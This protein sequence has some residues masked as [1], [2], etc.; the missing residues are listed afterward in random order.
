MA[1]APKFDLT[2]LRQ[3]L[4]RWSET[5]PDGG[6]FSADT[7][8]RWYRSQ[9]EPR[10]PSQATIAKYLADGKGWAGA[11]IA[12]RTAIAAV[13]PDRTIVVPVICRARRP[14]RWVARTL[15]EWADDPS[16][17]CERC[18]G[19]TIEQ[20]YPHLVAFLADPQD[21]QRVT[22]IW[23]AWV[24]PVGGAAHRMLDGSAA[25]VAQGKP[26]CRECRGRPFP[27]VPDAAKP[28]PEVG[29]VTESHN[30]VTSGVEQAVRDIL[31][32]AGYTVPER[33]LAIWCSHASIPDEV[34]TITPDI[35][36]V[37]HHVVVEVD[38]CQP[39]KSHHGSTHRGKEA[40]DRLRNEMLAEAGWTVLRL[41]L[42]AE[43][44]GHIGDRDVV[45]ES[46][47]V[48][49]KVAEA[50]LATLDDLV[51][52]RAPQVRFV[53]KSAAPR[54]PA[55]R[56]S[57]VVRISTYDY[58]DQSHIFT[59]YPDPNTDDRV[60]LR[61]AMD[62]RY[63][64]THDKPPLFLTEVG[65]QDVPQEQWR[66][67]LEATLAALPPLG[68]DHPK[69][70]WGNELLIAAQIG[71]GAEQVV[72]D[73]ERNSRIDRATVIFTT[74]GAAIDAWTR[75]A[76]LAADRSVLVSLHPDAVELG[77]RFVHVTGK[78]G[79][80]GPYSIITVTRELE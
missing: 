1:T 55:T 53:P 40:E 68:G 79:R 61:L 63:L 36:L 29:S 3:T 10:P 70:P 21:A 14:A 6:S 16:C 15:S 2:V 48:T 72:L 45:C 24:C 41:R 66:M 62:G 65:L 58:G 12:H 7:Y 28:R 32:G 38:P 25:W 4:D 23:V 78:N 51:H 46:A 44:G 64:Y 73:C 76:L 75:T 17:G 39:L 8:D 22:S 54:K 13:A 74:S 34:A 19:P 9:A 20:A 11:V 69:Y 71:V 26:Y 67:R 37:D 30:P 49:K 57:S 77:Y 33:K 35:V 60:Y 5:I 42:G 18:D 52:A 59:W 43:E 50:L 31:V 80:Y 27:K 56:R 47:T